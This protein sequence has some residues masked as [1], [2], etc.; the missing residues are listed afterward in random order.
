MPFP[1]PDFLHLQW[2]VGAIVVEMKLAMP[3]VFITLIKKKPKNNPAG[4]DK[5]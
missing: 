2:F 3:I 1:P 5:T 4:V